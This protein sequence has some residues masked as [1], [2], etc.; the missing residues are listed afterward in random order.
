MGQNESDPK[1]RRWK[2][3]ETEAAFRWLTLAGSVQHGRL[4][5]AMRHYSLPAYDVVDVGRHLL[6]ALS[7]PMADFGGEVSRVDMLTLSHAVI[8]YAVAHEW[9]VVAEPTFADEERAS[10]SEGAAE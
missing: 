1:A 6:R 8:E 3:P 4:E 10:G 5:Q 7:R 9:D 2:T